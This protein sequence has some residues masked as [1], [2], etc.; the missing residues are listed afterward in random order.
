MKEQICSVETI[1]IGESCFFMDVSC[2]FCLLN[3]VNQ[4]PPWKLFQF[5][6]SCPL[7]SIPHHGSSSLSLFTSS[8]A[9]HSSPGLVW[10]SACPSWPAE[11][12]NR[13]GILCSGLQPFAQL[14]ALLHSFCWETQRNVH[15]WDLHSAIRFFLKV[16]KM[17]KISWRDLAQIT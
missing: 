1:K 9:K 2:I 14:S 12:S 4:L 15:R 3:K 16:P 11:R 13:T 5:F 17:F 7:F 6:S 8:S 10:S